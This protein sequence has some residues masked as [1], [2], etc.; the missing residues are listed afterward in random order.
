MELPLQF[1][2]EKNSLKRNQRIVYH[3]TKNSSD[4][5]RLKY[6]LIINKEKKIPL[7]AFNDTL[8]FPYLIKT[9]KFL[10]ENRDDECIENIN[11]SRL[12][13]FPGFADS[14]MSKEVIVPNGQ[15]VVVNFEIPMD[16][17][18][19]KYFKNE[20]VHV[21]PFNRL[22]LPKLNLKFFRKQKRKKG[23]A[24]GSL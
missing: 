2:F 3:F 7:V 5:C 10:V 17:F 23:I 8:D 19:L 4:T 11:M 14:L 16:Y 9:C 12:L 6:S 22:Y 13:Y 18:Q 21:R 1:S 15:N 24:K 20:P